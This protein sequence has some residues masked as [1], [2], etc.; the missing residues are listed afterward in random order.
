LG[1]SW[2]AAVKLSSVVGFGRSLR[3]G[4]IVE[5]RG[6]DEIL[7]TLDAAGKLEGMPFQPEMLQYCGRQFRVAKVANKACDTIHYSGIRRIRNAVHLEGLRCDGSAHGGCQ[8]ACLLYWKEAWVRSV[9]SRI[10]GTRL[11]PR[12]HAAAR[13]CTMDGLKR[14]T[15]R[16]SNAEADLLYQCQVTELLR[17]SRPW[18]WWN[19][20]QYLSDVVTRNWS[21]RHVLQVLAL[22]ALRRAILTG[23]GYRMLIALYDRLAARFGMHAYA[24][25][26][27][28]FGPIPIGAQTPDSDFAPV[29]GDSVRVRSRAEIVATLNRNGRNRGMWFDSEMVGFCG[30]TYR[31]SHVVTRIIDEAT[32]RMLQ[33]KNPCIALDGVT[34]KA[35]YS[36]KRLMCPRAIVPY[37]RPGWLEKAPEPPPPATPPAAGSLPQPPNW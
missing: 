28:Q 2:E 31:V 24:V 29:A 3:A 5:I 32:G 9:G 8:A 7:A 17:A 16:S 4:D 11:L 26:V 14:A 19:P 10:A 21:V 36:G 15:R 30:G 22:A 25:I 23:T 37:W 12:Q 34:C 6:P 18:S 1:D 33:M 13:A 35:E 27:N 20:H